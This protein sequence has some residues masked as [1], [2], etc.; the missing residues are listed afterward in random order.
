VYQD[1][2]KEVSVGRGVLV[3]PERVASAPRMH[4]VQ[5]ER[6]PVVQYERA[7]VQYGSSYE[8]ST[9]AVQAAQY[10]DER[11]FPPV[12]SYD[13]RER[14]REREQSAYG[15]RQSISSYSSGYQPALGG[16]PGQPVTVSGG[17]QPA[18]GYAATTYGQQGSSYVM[19]YGSNGRAK[20]NNIEILS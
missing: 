1:R 7:P 15:G 8:R 3:E 11:S 16:Y 2:V 17:F 14:E 6:A 4:S 12:V 20:G 10:R 18:G 9:P 19:T 13:E 5:Y